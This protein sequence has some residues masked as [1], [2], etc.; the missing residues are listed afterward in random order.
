MARHL[1]I[2][3]VTTKIL[4]Y[5]HSRFEYNPELGR[6]ISKISTRNHNCGHRAG[7]VV[8]AVS[9]THL[10]LPTSHNV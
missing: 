10:T 2:T 8:K 3:K 4:E 5:I 9:Y 7:E 6:L 1:T